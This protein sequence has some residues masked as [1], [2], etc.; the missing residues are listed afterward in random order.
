MSS[1]PQPAEDVIAFA[2]K[3]SG[4]YQSALAVVMLRKKQSPN[5]VTYNRLLCLA[6]SSVGW[7]GLWVGF[8]TT[9]RVF[10]FWDLGWKPPL[11]GTS[12]SDGGWQR[13]KSPRRSMQAQQNPL[14]GVASYISPAHKSISQS[15]SCGPAQ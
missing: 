5:S 2:V 11:S 13:L 14:L 12:C 1:S 10:L 9:Q 6:H 4:L 7:V 15:N 3:S 8:R